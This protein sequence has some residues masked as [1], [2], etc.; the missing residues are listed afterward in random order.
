MDIEDIPELELTLS[1]WRKIAA[2]SENKAL[3]SFLSHLEDMSDNDP[4][5]LVPARSDWVLRLASQLND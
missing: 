4:F 3:Q 1:E 5:V 2:A